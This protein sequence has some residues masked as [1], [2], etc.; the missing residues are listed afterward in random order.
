MAHAAA[1][2]QIILYILTS[3]AV[4]RTILI[5][6]SNILPAGA[7]KGFGKEARKLRT[8]ADVLL[9]IGALALWNFDIH[10]PDGMLGRQPNS[11]RPPV[12]AQLPDALTAQEYTQLGRQLQTVLDHGGSAG[13][14]PGYLFCQV[15]D[16][17]EITENPPIV[18]T[19]AGQELAVRIVA[20]PDH[21]FTVRLIDMQDPGMPDHPGKSPCILL[22]NN[23]LKLQAGIY[24]FRFA[25]GDP[26]K[27]VDALTGQPITN[28]DG[29]PAA[30]GKPIERNK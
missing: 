4:Y 24:A 5:T 30:I 27:P 25:G 8:T 23:D 11:P 10:R 3:S 12:T 19:A 15:G 18:K 26:T 29:T 1:Q 14:E 6:M 17:I 22:P 16:K 13:F 9:L 20:S 28:K 2:Q 21:T 7:R